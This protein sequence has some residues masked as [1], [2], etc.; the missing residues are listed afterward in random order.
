MANTKVYIPATS[1]LVYVDKGLATPVPYSPTDLRIIPNYTDGVV[2]LI[3]K[4]GR[5]LFSI[6]FAQIVV[7]ANGTKATATFTLINVVAGNE[8]IVNGIVYTGVDGVKANN[9]QFSVDTSDAL[10]TIDLADSITNDDRVG[11]TIPT[12]DVDASPATNVVTVTA[13]TAFA[14]GNSID[15]SSGAGTIVASSATLLTGADPASIGVDME[16][17]IL[18]LAVMIE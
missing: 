7:E 18:A 16:A 17:T 6:P 12:M 4:R 14:L 9:T 11:I 3:T 1:K 10:A 8:V 13:K 2:S 5:E 15:I